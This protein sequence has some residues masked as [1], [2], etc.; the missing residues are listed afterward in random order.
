MLVNKDTRIM[1]KTEISASLAFL[2]LPMEQRGLLKCK[3]K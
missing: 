3:I 2:A 1:E